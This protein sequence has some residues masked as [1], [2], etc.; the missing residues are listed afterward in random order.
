MRTFI[1]S[2][3]MVLVA[4]N[5]SFAGDAEDPADAFAK[6]YASLCLQH[7]TNL[8]SLRGKL[9]D[10]P[11]LTPEQ[12][13]HFLAGNQGDAWPIADNTGTFVL[14]LPSNKNICAVYARRADASKAER[15]FV[16]LV[17]HSPA[18]M[19][20]R[21]VR[22]ERAHTPANGPTHTVSYEWSLPN[23]ARKMLFTI[24]TAT[25]DDAQL[26]VL[27]SATMTSN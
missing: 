26:Q 1:L 24:T 20:S 18:P 23:A 17:G 14:A 13:M 27:G 10:M 19:V 11:K 21:L 2:L 7:I 25:S 8:D 6:I 16:A 22:D 4:F 12:S 3:V 9:R 5:A 15:L